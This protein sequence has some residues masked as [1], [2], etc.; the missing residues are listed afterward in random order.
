MTVY[1][2]PFK[3][4]GQ[5]LQ[6]TPGDS[7][8]RVQLGDLK[9]NVDTA[10]LFHVS[11]SER[12]NH[13]RGRAASSTSSPG[14]ASQAGGDA[15]SSEDAMLLPQTSDNSVDL[16]GMRADEA[17]DKLDLF[18][19]SAYL[20][21]IEGVYI[22]HGH[23]TGALKRAVRGHLP[24]SRYVREFRRGEREE[25]GDGVTIAFLKRGS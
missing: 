19:D 1:C 20:Q 11:E 3:R 7:Q 4:A 16:R 24:Q 14:R 25:G 21:N 2:R 23:G 12:R 15:A 17:I 5:I 18:L 22:I 10:D 6:W 13:R 8:A 9:V